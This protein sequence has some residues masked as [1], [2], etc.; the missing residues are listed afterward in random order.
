MRQK[1]WVNA[2]ILIAPNATN[3]VGAPHTFTVT[4]QQDT[5]GGLRARSGA[6]VPCNVTLTNANGAVANPA[7]PFN[8]VTNASGQCSVDVHLG[9]GRHR[10]RSCVLDG[11]DQRCRDPGADQRRRAEQR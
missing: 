8:Q 10:D 3:E 2:R 11:D 6:G 4:V 5:G 9:D 1:T 7:G